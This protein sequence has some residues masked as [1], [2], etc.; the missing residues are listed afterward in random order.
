[1]KIECKYCKTN[2]DNE[3]IL[4]YNCSKPL[5]NKEEL[6]ER[7]SNR[8]YRLEQTYQQEVKA[9]RKDISEFNKIEDSTSESFVLPEK[10]TT[11]IKEEKVKEEVNLHYKDTVIQTEPPKIKT[12]EPSTPSPFDL[13]V[14]EL[15][16]PINE[17]VELFLNAYTKYK[18]EG[19]LPIFF[20]TMAG[21]VTILF[22]FGY[23]MQLSL[24]YLGAYQEP[25]KIGLG[26]A[27]S[28]LIGAIGIRLSRREKTL[29][30]YGSALISLGIILNYLMIYFMSDLGSFPVLS[31]GILGFSLICINTL[32]SIF[33]SLKYEAKVISS[34]S[35]IGGAFAPLYLNAMGDGNLYF[36]YLWL[37]AAG[38]CY[39]AKKTDWKT[40]NYLTFAVT[41]G[42]LEFMVFNQSPSHLIYTAYYHLFAYLFFFLA[43]FDGFRLKNSL[44]KADIV[45]L[46]SSL[47]IFLYNLFSAFES[48]LFTLGIVYAINGLV[49]S[50]LML[51]KWK[52]LS[53]D[54]K[55]VLFVVI[56]ALI[57]F[58]IPSIFDW[59]LMGLFWSIEALLLVILGFHFSLPTVRKEGYILLAIA[60]GKLSLSSL[61]IIAHWDET[62][63]HQGFLNYMALGAVFSSMWFIGRKQQKK[64]VGFENALYS[65]TQELVPLWLS[66]IYLI[67]GYNLIG[68]W[69]FNLSIMPLFG[70]IYWKKYFN[71]Q[72]SDLL[73]LSHLLLFLAGFVIS[74]Q[75]TGSFH[76]SDQRLYAQIA[77]IE[78][79]ATL[80]A[81]KSF[82]RMLE[83]EDGNTFRFTHNLRITFFCLLPLLFIN[84]VRKHA[85]EFI[86][87]GLWIGAII[88][89][90]LSK[91]LKYPALQIE[92]YL[93]SVIGFFL[94][95]MDWD[96]VG[97]LSGI[98]FIVSIVMAEKAITYET[99]QKSTYKHY[100]TILPF[101]FTVFVGS[102]IFSLNEDFLPLSLSISSFLLLALTYFYDKIGPIK[103]NF[104][105][106]GNIGLVLNLCSILSLVFYES[107]LS[108]IFSI[109]NLVIFSLLLHNKK[110]WF[111]VLYGQSWNSVL[112]L[113]Q[114]E[115]ILTY[116]LILT[117]VGISVTGPL[118]SILLAAHAII[119]LFVA[120][121]NQ[122]KILNK[123]S[124]VL[125]AATLLKVVLHD[126]ND[127]NTTQK[128]FVF[129]ILGL[130]LL[131]ASYG[132]VKLAKHFEKK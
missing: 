29:K 85:F 104:K 114:M 27:S 53:R 21:I 61:S 102:F 22:G 19:K 12:R 15:L 130:I 35:L 50:S 9:I 96:P 45:I 97:I 60:F 56:G 2:N 69:I 17:G 63:W 3:V 121:K 122:I 36:L 108:M 107:I 16:R 73:G 5:W 11:P 86:E 109:L 42:S 39:V 72:L 103:N 117:F 18:S 66:S 126:I 68:E 106:A 30:E 94:C 4:C 38:S 128:V 70:F 37:L 92:L 51:L 112:V 57:G 110:N 54:T 59:K 40:L 91:K 115:C 62:I 116:G 7:I 10:K 32:V 127:F 80:W 129:I 46:V 41:L 24:K 25:F 120:M 132:Y 52:D 75:T 119:L 79:L 98:A 84:L 71:T 111:P 13:K 105:L 20:M 89:Y 100:I 82:Y 65:Y 58:A 99:L 1:M 81:L 8:L 31:S 64:L 74:I 101:V 78:F 48:N 124:I 47:S 26:F 28:I 67:I 76:I 95:Y 34:I 123:I 33:F 44:D 88:T 83:I 77:I 93:L 49:F 55:L 131:G 43:L 113:H 125:F 14:K 6:A 23:L 90:F 87:L 118:A